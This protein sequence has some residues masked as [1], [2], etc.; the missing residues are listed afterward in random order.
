MVKFWIVIV[1]SIDWNKNNNQLIGKQLIGE[2][3]IVDRSAD[4][5]H[6]YKPYEGGFMEY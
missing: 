2:Q 5:N 4:T 3:Q 6:E 1:R